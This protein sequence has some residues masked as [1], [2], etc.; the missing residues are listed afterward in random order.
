MYY[1][2]QHTHK[3][4]LSG[5]KQTPQRYGK[6]ETKLPA[7]NK[8]LIRTF[9]FRILGQRCRLEYL[10]LCP[11]AALISYTGRRWE[12]RIATTGREILLQVR[13]KTLGTQANLE[14]WHTWMHSRSEW[15]RR[16]LLA[17]SSFIYEKRQKGVGIERKTERPREKRWVRQREWESDK[18]F[19]QDSGWGKMRERVLSCVLSFS[20]ENE[21]ACTQCAESKV[22][23]C[24]ET[25]KRC[26]TEPWVTTATE[27]TAKDLYSPKNMTKRTN[28]IRKKRSDQHIAIKRKCT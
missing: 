10:W 16:S 18:G 12:W 9:S 5:A 4:G 22:P 25:F 2:S 20:H 17:F 11:W 28:K 19:I 1:L 24:S 13:V 8:V 3:P 7:K 23:L 27:S 6:A 21:R 14:K 15:V 26:D